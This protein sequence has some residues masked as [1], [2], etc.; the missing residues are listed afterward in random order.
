MQAKPMN[1]ALRLLISLVS[2]VLCLALGVAIAATIL[3]ADVQTLKN[4]DNMQQI[5]HQLMFGAEGDEDAMTLAEPVNAMVYEMMSEQFE[6]GEDVPFTQ[7]DVDRMME[8]STF[9]E[10]LS[11]KLAGVMLDAFNGESTTTITGDEIIKE[12]EKNE[13]LMK[14]EM[15][16]EMDDEFKES[17]K[18]WVSENN[19]V[20]TME[21][22]VLEEDA[23]PSKKF[24]DGVINALISGEADF[25]DIME[26]GFPVI[27]M[28]IRE[29]T[30]A[31]TLLT[32]IGITLLIAGLVILINFKQ[33]YVG[34]RKV[35]LS[36]ITSSAIF[37][38]VSIFALVSPESFEGPFLGVIHLILT[39]MAAVPI[40]ILAAGVALVV[41]SI[42]LSVKA[43]KK[44]IAAAAAA[45]ATP[46]A[47][48]APAAAPAPV[49]IVINNTVNAEPTVAEAPAEEK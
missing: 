47:P 36:A 2:A 45:M 38:A 17:V 46:V 19:L 40:A 12:L 37:A 8:K 34:M 15:D 33:I 35:G 13:A 28:M 11:G 21:E 9:S 7:E 22:E 30:S 32:V 49:N 5:V 42:V 10:F 24:D 43:K 26:G 39:M 6:E 31:E 41:V 1:P 48:V 25:D 3:L 4:P 23:K 16:F 44:M 29:I 27:M 20:D 14:E 18:E